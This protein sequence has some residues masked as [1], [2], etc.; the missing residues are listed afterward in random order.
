MGATEYAELPE[1]SASS[2]DWREEG[3]VS[4]VKNQQQ[5]GS[6][7]AFSAT[8]AIESA[9]A[10]K[11]GSLQS[12]SEQQLIDCDPLNHGCEGGLMDTAMKYIESHP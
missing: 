5:C 3:K 9:N 12:F 10:I 2:I 6:C 4:E 7:W 8:G 11:Y 1:P